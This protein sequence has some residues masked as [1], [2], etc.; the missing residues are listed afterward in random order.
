M[1]VKRLELRGCNY[2]GYRISNYFIYIKL[3]GKQ[4]VHVLNKESSSI[5]KLKLLSNY[6]VL[7]NFIMNY[8]P[9]TQK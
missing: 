4:T 6:F 7:K 8:I 1:S 2:R 3:E 5:R 9:F